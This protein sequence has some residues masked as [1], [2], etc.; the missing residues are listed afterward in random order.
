LS[1]KRPRDFHAAAV[2]VREA[3]GRVVDARRQ[4]LAEERDDLARLFAQRL[5]LAAHGT[6]L[7]QRQRQ[8]G[9]RPQPRNAGHARF[10]GAQPRVRADQHVVEHREV[11]EHAPML[12]GA[13]QPALRELLG[14]QAGDVLPVEQHL[15]FVGLVQPGHQVEQRGLA[16]AVRP[17]HAE[18]FALAH[19]Q[20]H[21]VRRP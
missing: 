20:V 6:G 13:R 16:R 8:L 11:R 19:V 1:A 21:R 2:G 17:D 7:H 15:P 3:V 5:F 4:A 18:Q 12:E 14:R 10:H 9:Q